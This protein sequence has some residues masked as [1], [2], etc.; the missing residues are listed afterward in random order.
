M[1]STEH[2]VCSQGTAKVGPDRPLETR[3][4]MRHP[5]TPYCETIADSER[6]QVNSYAISSATPDRGILLQEK[7]TDDRG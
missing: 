6:L 4:P 7:A 1:D 2:T 3:L 5:Y